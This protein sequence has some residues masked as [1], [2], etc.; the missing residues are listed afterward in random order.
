MINDNQ[1]KI[2]EDFTSIR[3][4]KLWE[5]YPGIYRAIVI[6]TNDPLNMFRVQFKCPDLHDY[7]MRDVDCPWA[8]S[9]CGGVSSGH[10]QHPC[11]G[12]YVWIA[13]ERSHPY[14]PVWLGIASPTRRR[15]YQ[16]PSIHTRTPLSLDSNG[17]LI[18]EPPDDYNVEYLP[19]DSRP[20]SNGFVDRYGNLD[21]FSAVGFRPLSHVVTNQSDGDVSSRLQEPQVTPNIPDVKLI[22]RIT[23]YGNVV[24]MSD[25]GYTWDKDGEYGEFVG[26]HGIDYNF[27]VDRW[28][29]L[30]RVITNDKSSEYDGR[31]NKIF[32]RYGHMFEQRD[33]GWAQPGPISSK[34]RVGEYAETQQ[35]L[36]SES[37]RDERWMRIRTKG[38]MLTQWSDV[39]SHP[40]LDTEISKTTLDFVKEDDNSAWIGRDG[41]MIRNVSRHGYKIVIDDR[42]SSVVDAY[43][44]ET[45]RGNG[46]LLKGRRTPSC[47]T[48]N[49]TGDQRGYWLEMNENDNANRISMGSPLGSLL[50]INDA[51]E[52]VVLATSIG[53]DYAT[54]W[55]GLD[56]N[57]FL[58]EPARNRDIENVAFH[59]I[60]DKQ[61]Q[62]IRLKSPGSN[63][64]PACDETVNPIGIDSSSIP[65]GLEIRTGSK[66]DGPWVEINDSD[67]RG[68]FFHRDSGLTI[69]RSRSDKGLYVWIDDKNNQIVI[70]SD[71]PDS[72]IQFNSAGSVEIIATDVKIDASNNVE[73]KA[74]NSFKIDGGG[75]LMTVNSDAVSTMGDINASKVYASIDVNG[76]S[77]IEVGKENPDGSPVDSVKP[78]DKPDVVEPSD[79]GVIYNKPVVALDGEINPSLDELYANQGF[80]LNDN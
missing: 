13:F 69:L 4:S 61:N 53:T 10:W 3:S 24:L 70:K 60:L 77:T 9:I 14:G 31:G 18:N 20:M 56:D 65:S 62:F 73:I 11:K 38:G 25:Q 19:T 46:I 72:R 80:S 26:D 35:Y 2:W 67:G 23:K 50:E 55:R 41:R 34:S 17:V 33:V 7:N 63:Q 59:L 16:Y 74:G 15:F 28:K 27:E 43:N 39:G 1:D 49:A 36:S 51:T 8:T 78:I 76:D 68:I 37:Q 6:D 64:I 42:G 71:Q 44:L 57:E 47:F 75:N 30:Q 58:T 66:G 32:T 22:S 5:R 48:N 79:R 52:Y 29:Y 54:Q 12:D 45:P 40:G 21:L